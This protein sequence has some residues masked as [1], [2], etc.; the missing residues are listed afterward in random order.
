M[1]T[2]LPSTSCRLVVKV[3]FSKGKRYM[4]KLSHKKRD[5][6]PG[7]PCFDNYIALSHCT[8]RACCFAKI[9]KLNK[10]VSE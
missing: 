2:A 1:E 7:L 10:I 5:F 4:F 8:I 6:S 9:S 3:I